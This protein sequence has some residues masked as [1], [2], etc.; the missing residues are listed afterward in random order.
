MPLAVLRRG[1]RTSR[2][3]AE[4]AFLSEADVRRKR[5]LV[6]ETHRL[7]GGFFNAVNDTTILQ[8]LPALNLLQ[9]SN[10][11]ATRLRAMPH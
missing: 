8:F 2:V 9:R 1:R 10:A 4:Q 3:A 5:P 11:Q 6:Q 7:A